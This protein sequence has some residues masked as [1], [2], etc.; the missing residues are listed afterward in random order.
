MNLNVFEFSAKL[1]SVGNL[2][3]LHWNW[4]KMLLKLL[5]FSNLE[6]E[7]NPMLK[8]NKIFYNLLKFKGIFLLFLFIFFVYFIIKL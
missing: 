6:I 4:E 7:E 2:L 5:I 8:L 3:V 1:I